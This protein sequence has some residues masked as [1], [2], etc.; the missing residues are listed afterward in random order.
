[1]KT[2]SKCGVS[3]PSSEFFSSK[4]TR[5]GLRSWCKSCHTSD[6]VARAAKVGPSKKRVAYMAAYKQRPE[7]KAANAKGK[8]EKSVE[9]HLFRAAKERA[10]REHLDFSITQEDITVPDVCPLLGLALIRGRNTKGANPE[11]PTLDRVD[12][13]LGYVKGNIWVISWRANR[14]K[15]DATLD[16]L[17][18]LVS[19][20]ASRVGESYGS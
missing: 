16:E 9:Y 7:V 11:S 5:D 18:R 13:R 12:P 20:L 2:C 17:T 10:N 1:M 6:N 19:G 3:K 15:S 4:Q 8:R 14:L